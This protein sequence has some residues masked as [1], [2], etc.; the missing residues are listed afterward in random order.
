MAIVTLV[1]PVLL[2]LP[3]STVFATRIS[4]ITSL[5]TDT[6]ADGDTADYRYRTVQPADDHATCLHTR[7]NAGLGSRNAQ[8]RFSRAQGDDLTAAHQLA[9]QTGFSEVAD[10]LFARQQQLIILRS[11]AL[12]NGVSIYVALGGDLKDRRT[13]PVP[14]FTVPDVLAVFAVRALVIYAGPVLVKV[15]SVPVDRHPLLRFSDPAPVEILATDAASPLLLVGDHAGNLIP[16]A[17]GDLGLGDADRTRHIAWDI[18]IDDLGRSLSASLGATFIRQRYSRLVIDCNRDPAS[19]ESICIESD[20]T[21]IPGNANL[22]HIARSQR[23]AEI[24][25]P[26]QAAIAAILL[27][28]PTAILISLHSFAPALTCPGEARPWHIGV[29][30]DGHNDTFAKRLLDWLTRN[31]GLTIGDNAPY[32]MNATDYTVPRHAFA[33]GLPYAELEVRQDLLADAQGTAKIAEILTA[34]LLHAQ[35]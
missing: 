9:V 6:A 12:H 11:T 23:I 22:G 17:F 28:R 1:V 30:H 26:Y 2:A 34:A 19:L 14:D 5:T 20:A 7:V 8:L 32:R 18:G 25:E 4:G 10:A 35:G 16:G 15:P 31:S 21:P 24:H 27:L 29:L 3:A 13:A 33:A